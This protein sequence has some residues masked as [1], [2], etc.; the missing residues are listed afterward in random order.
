MNKLTKLL[1][2][3]ISSVAIA[4]SAFAG[5]F[6]V[7]GS[8][9]ATYTVLGATGTGGN[10]AGTHASGKGIG[11][12]NE[13]TLSASGELDNG[14]T[15][16]YAQDID[17]ATVQDD[18]SI[19]IGTDYGTVKICVSECGLSTKYAFDNSAYG[20]ASD[21]GYGGGSTSSGASANTMQ[22]G[23]NISSYNNIQYHTPADLLPLGITVKAAMTPGRAGGTANDSV[24][25][26]TGLTH[27]GEMKQYA[28]TMAP[29]DGLT[30]S[31]SYYDFGEMG[32][33][34]GRQQQEG[35]SLGANYSIGQVSVGYGETKHAP[36]QR[37]TSLAT[38]SAHIQH[39]ENDAYSIGFAVNDSLSISYAEENS[40]M[41]RKAK[42]VS[43]ATTRTDVEMEI[44]EIA[45]AYTIGGATISVSNSETS[46]DSYVVGD[47]TT[48]S[49]VAISLA[50]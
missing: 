32:N 3:V 42:S 44:T 33:K 45:A 39:Y 29:V 8:A 13:F 2:S 9:K 6:T 25:S 23:S 43:G 14:M 40:E 30:I 49:I 20:V 19:A 31:A 36:A 41:K 35:G 12:S 27:N 24:H 11:I 4:T 17:N 50:F 46:N 21:N 1:F 15:W 48:E 7:S 22:Y 26:T 5:E 47:D 37:M 16:S 18:A 28:V 34:D 38:A 10:G